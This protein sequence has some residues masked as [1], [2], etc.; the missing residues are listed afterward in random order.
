MVQ[1]TREEQRKIWL[2]E[3]EHLSFAQKLFGVTISIR[4]RFTVPCRL[5]RSLSRMQSS[6]TIA[7]TDTLNI[8]PF[9][10]NPVEM[11]RHG[12][13]FKFNVNS[14][15]LYIKIRFRRCNDLENYK[16]H[17]EAQGMLADT[18]FDDLWPLHN[19]LR[20]M[21]VLSTLIIFELE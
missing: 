16:P 4:V 1:S 19:D 14:M 18:E 13:E 9:E 2:E 15:V 6:R 21:V 8:V 12:I 5:A 11:I 10:S 17:L 3:L 20:L 7:E